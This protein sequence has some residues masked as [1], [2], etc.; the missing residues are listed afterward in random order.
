VEHIRAAAAP[1]RDDPAVLPP[2][3]PGQLVL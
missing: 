2:A 1:T 3:V